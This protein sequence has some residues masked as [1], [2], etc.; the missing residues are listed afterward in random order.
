MDGP[1]DAPAIEQDQPTEAVSAPSPGEETSAPE[2]FNENFD[3]TSL[4]DELQPA[5][6]QMQGAFTKKTQEI[7]EQRKAAESAQAFF[8][9]LN[10]PEQRSDAIRWLAENYGEEAVYEALG[11]DV[12]EDEEPEDNTDD[13]F[14]DPRVD[15][16]LQER[17]QQK[18]AAQ[19]EAQL[20]HIEK[21]VD[22]QFAEVAKAAGYELDEDEQQAILADA[23]SSFPPGPDGAPQVKAAFERH[24]RIWEKRQKK[25]IESKQGHNPAPT[26]QPG[27]PKFDIRDRD[28]R[29]KRMAAIMEAGEA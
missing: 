24:Q 8:T 19:Q 13:R 4:P 28:E 15:E 1:T 7:A 21:L 6:K 29:I 12:S 11:L 10:D 5:Y 17:E 3:P 18:Q 26:G 25:W 22:A 23:I 16:L 20:A 2:F 9:A 14:R 27:Q